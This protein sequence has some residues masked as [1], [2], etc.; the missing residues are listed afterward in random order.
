MGKR[1]REHPLIEGLEITAV[2]AEGKAMGHHDGVVVFVPLAVP[3]DVVDVQ[4]RSHR[5]RFMEGY[6][7]RWVVRS[8]LRVEPVCEHFGVCGGCSW[9]HLPYDEQLRYKRQQV[10]DQLSRIGHLE[11]PAEGVRPA[12]GS[13]ATTFYRNKLE[14]TF[15]PKRWLTH[16]EMREES[17]RQEGAADAPLS[18]QPAL[19][20]HVPGMF[21]KVLDVRKCWLQPD[22]SNEIR[23]ELKRFC[24]ERGYEFYDIR[25][26]TGL[27][28]NVVV[29]TASTGEVMVIVVFAAEAPERIEELMNHLAATFP[30][31]TSLM[32]MVNTKLNDSLGDLEAR[33]WA[34]RDHIFEQMEG[35][36]F[37]IGP[38]SFYQTNSA[39]A[40]ELYKVAREFAGLTGSESR[41]ADGDKNDNLPVVY[42][43]YTGTGTIA[44]FVAR[45]AASV[46]G[47]EYVP[48]AIAD[49]RVNSA[50]NGITNTLFYAGDMKKILVDAFIAANGHPDVVILDPPRAGVDP[51]VI[52]VILRAA[53]KV[54]VYV[55]CNPATQARDLAL[56]SEAYTIAAVQPVDMFP[57]THHIENVVKLIRK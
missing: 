56:M 17:T 47:I 29:R 44:N 2:A 15:A 51:P 21:D 1:R 37:K 22:P 49:A 24:V 18:P 48:E 23:L 5:R 6:V 42:D 25:G 43:L 34:G 32:Y 38:K 45:D 33:L 50:L 40:H 4:V 14:F 8:P 30:A 57:H 7:V 27:M 3:G 19:G 12:I 55:S 26:H 11:L 52:D 36:R 28:R 35:L 31:I 9:Q 41:D 13:A 20:F 16:E 46:V 39:Q 54:I 10:V 53:P